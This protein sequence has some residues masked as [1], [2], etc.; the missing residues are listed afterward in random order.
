MRR[1]RVGWGDVVV[2]LSLVLI[3]LAVVLSVVP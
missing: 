1:R 2:V 3:A